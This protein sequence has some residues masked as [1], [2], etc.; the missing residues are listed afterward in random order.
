MEKKL[1]P[2][3]EQEI[4]QGELGAFHCSRKQGSHQSLKGLK[5]SQKPPKRTPTGQRRV[6]L[7][8]K[9]NDDC[10]WLKYTE[11]IKIHDETF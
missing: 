6:N 3:L 2:G 5:R 1:I 8:T 10:N 4:I 11:Y 9:M 7:S